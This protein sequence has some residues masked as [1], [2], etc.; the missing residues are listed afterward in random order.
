MRVL[1]ALWEGRPHLYPSVPLAWALYAAG[2]DVRVACDR[3]LVDE[4]VRAGLPAVPVGESFDLSANVR[5]D[6]DQL[7]VTPDPPAQ[8]LIA[9][10][11][12]SFQLLA[13][14]NDAVLAD[15][16]RFAER[17]RPDLVLWDPILF[18]GR[19]AARRVGAVDARILFGLDL[20]VYWRQALRQLGVGLP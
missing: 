9:D 17:W 13:G 4:V 10:A 14:F 12:K 16:T 15:L 1:F 5:Q 3:R 20:L 7:R 8:Q 2:H 18:A 11:M 19:V 6:P